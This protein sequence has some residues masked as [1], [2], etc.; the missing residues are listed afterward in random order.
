VHV[1]PAFST[2]FGIEAVNEPLMNPTLTPGYGDC[3]WLMFP[4]FH[5]ISNLP[6]LSDLTD[7]TRVIRAME[8]TLGI[9]CPGVDYISLFGSGT[10]PTNASISISAEA[11]V[12][13]PQLATS[14]GG[15]VGQILTSII[16]MIQ[17]VSVELGVPNPLL[18]SI[19]GGLLGGVN[20]ECVH[21]TYVGC[22]SCP[23]LFLPN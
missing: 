5:E 23:L 13:L 10:H 21:T 12:S 22:F 4:S 17:S 7:F 8:L 2:V 19:L 14:L 1:D 11:S 18:S 6:Y 3:K 9:F 15:R 20:R 16:P